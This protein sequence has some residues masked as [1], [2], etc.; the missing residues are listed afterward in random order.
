M[1]DE[2]ISICI[3]TYRRPELLR[4]A[5]ESCFQQNYRPL[6]ILVGDDSG[7]D[8]SVSVIETLVCPEGITVRHILN[9]PPLRQ[10]RNVHS[11]FAKAS[12]GRLVLLHDDDL[13]CDRGLDRLVEIWEQHPGLV[14]VYGKQ[15]V[16]SP[17]GEK[18]L[19]NTEDFNSRCG[20]IH[21]LQG[22]QNSPLSAGLSQQIPN[23]CF[24]VE[25]R[26]AQAVNYRSEE[27]VGNSVDADFGIRLGQAAEDKSF[28]YIDEFVSCYRL[29]EHSI[30]RRRH[31]NYGEHLLYSSLVNLEVPERDVAA[32]DQS[33]KN[34]SAKAVLNAAMA[35]QRKLALSILFS[36]HYEL[37]YTDIRSIFRLLYI[38]SPWLGNRLNRLLPSTR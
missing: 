31:F 21:E 30:L 2:L 14:C 26:L 28:Y 29:T 18:L 37:R 36:R 7:D 34:F 4:E 5:I 23:N 8:T 27:E 17:D 13:L 20:R 19:E 32:R 6:E 10:A 22:I 3:P 38:A 33:L 16:I 15:Y 25:T 24:L 35:G 12:G 9:D 11:L 1:M